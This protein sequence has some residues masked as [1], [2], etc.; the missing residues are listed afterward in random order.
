MDY[1]NFQRIGSES[2]AQAGS[3][4]EE[5][6][7]AFFQTQGISLTK[8][9]PI[10]VGVAGA[11]EGTKIRPREPGPANHCGMQI[12]QVDTRREH[13][14]RQG[15]RVERS[16]VLLDLAPEEYRKIFF[17]LKDTRSTTCGPADR[18]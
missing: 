11:K 18:A 13:T 12:K 3:D 8:N 6:A 4:F 1:N 7:R 10:E 16:H 15:D 2:N 14:Q 9:F 5:T 17:V